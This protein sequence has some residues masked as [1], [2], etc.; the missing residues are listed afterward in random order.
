[1]FYSVR[2]YLRRASTS[3]NSRGFVE[4]AE[5]EI[6]SP[7]YTHSSDISHS[8]S[9]QTRKDS[10]HTSPE[11]CDKVCRGLSLL[12]SGKGVGTRAAELSPINNAGKALTT[13]RADVLP[14]SLWR[15]AR[16]QKTGRYACDCRSPLLWVLGG[17]VNSFNSVPRVPA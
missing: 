9:I 8:T 1:M 4:D 13:K 6:D 2:Q 5:A 10:K 11:Q 15:K 3:A 12:W 17:F 7:R 16:V 14:L